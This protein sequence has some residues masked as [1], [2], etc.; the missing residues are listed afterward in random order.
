MATLYDQYGRKV[1]TGILKEERAAATIAGIRNIYSTVHVAASIT[2]ERLTAVLR[3]AEFGNPYYYLEF[4]QD[5]EERDLH[6]LAVLSTRKESVACLEPAIRAASK[7]AQDQKI[8]EYVEEKLF[9]RTLDLPLLDILDAIGKGF[10]VCEI[11]WNQDSPREWYPQ[12]I[13]YRDPRWFMFDWISGEEAL[14]RTLR[15]EGQMVPI[16][17]QQGKVSPEPG[18]LGQIGIQPATAPLD[19]F[20]FVTHVSKAKAGLPIRGG[21][22]RA[23]A[24]AYL[25]KSYILKDWVTFCEVYGQPLR[26][27]K[28][29]PGATEED[30]NTLLTAIASIGT[31]SAAIIPDSMLIEFVGAKSVTQNGE[32][33]HRAVEYIDDSISKAVLGQTLTSGMPSRG[34]GSRAAAQVHDAVRR[35]ILAFDVRRLSATITRDLVIPMVQLTFGEQPAY[36]RFW[37]SVPADQDLKTQSDVIAEMVDRGL[38]VGQDYVRDMLGIPVPAAG[39][40]VLKPLSRGGQSV[41]QN[42]SRARIGPLP[43]GS[44]VAR[45]VARVKYS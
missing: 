33:Y 24:W 4:A 19:P 43:I 2:P 25:F 27:G 35:D 32:L 11:I 17:Q 42:T 34:G 39:E 22:A 40:A 16:I 31:D 10:S 5:I 28:Y 1:D 30:K 9:D 41:G 23:A 3:Q 6:Y 18:S 36:P 20:K 38:E 37:L 8:A 21:L 45:A 44:A 7:S 13:K 14:V 15:T 29:N 12:Q 26:V